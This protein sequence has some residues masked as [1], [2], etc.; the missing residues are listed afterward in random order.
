MPQPVL[1]EDNIRAGVQPMHRD[2]VSVMPRA[3]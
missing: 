3:E 1:Y 2:R